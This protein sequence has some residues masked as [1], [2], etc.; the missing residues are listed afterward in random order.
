[1][2]IKRVLRDIAQKK[3]AKLHTLEEIAWWLEELEEAKGDV[4]ALQ[5]LTF[6]IAFLFALMNNLMQCRAPN[7]RI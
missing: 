4:Q 3:N 1:M 2:I 7:P 6:V 5:L